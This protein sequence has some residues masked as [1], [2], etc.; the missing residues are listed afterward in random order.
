LPSAIGRTYTGRQAGWPGESPQCT[1][2]ASDHGAI[3]IVVSEG[4][5]V[6][7]IDNAAYLSLY[8]ADLQ[9][10][11]LYR[12]ALYLRLLPIMNMYEHD[13]KP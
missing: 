7:G 13:I 6:A 9:R 1:H 10:P 11:Y 3:F 4:Y 5:K 8:S 12:P 2:V